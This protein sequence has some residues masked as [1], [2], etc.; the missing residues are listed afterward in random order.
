MDIYISGL[1]PE[2]GEASLLKLFS[3]VGKVDSVRLIRDRQSG[4]PTGYAVVDMG[5]VDGAEQAIR[6]LNG[7]SVLGSPILVSKTRPKT[8]SS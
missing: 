2:I 1:V 4:A 8:K 7:K 6:V 5:S 3:A